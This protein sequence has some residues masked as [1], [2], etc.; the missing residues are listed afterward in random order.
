[1]SR[2]PIGRA[3]LC[4]EKARRT[5][6]A[7]S[8]PS[9]RRAPLRCGL[10]DIPSLGFPP[11]ARPVRRRL[12]F[13]V[14]DEG[15]IN[16]VQRIVRLINRNRPAARG[17]G[18]EFTMHDRDRTTI[19]QEHDE[20]LKR[21]G[22]IEVAKLF[23]RHRSRTRPNVENGLYG[24]S[25]H[26]LRG[27][28]HV[29]DRFEPERRARV[30]RR[31]L[32]MTL[33]VNRDDRLRLARSRDGFRASIGGRRRTKARD[34]RGRRGQESLPLWRC[35]GNWHNSYTGVASA[36]K[37]GPAPSRGGDVSEFR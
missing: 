25:Y 34:D 16:E 33:V 37:G 11:L 12:E 17:R 7:E 3:C 13:Q 26:R 21:L 23:D 24:S 36:H 19:C 18:H 2:S 4:H 8:G 1:M 28:L 32:P 20:R 29:L 9:P 14:R 6:S 15:E 22:I 35:A 5:R 30:G 31:E 10:H 27:R